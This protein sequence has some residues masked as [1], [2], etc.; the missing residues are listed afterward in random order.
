MKTIDDYKRMCVKCHRN[1]DK[2]RKGVSKH[3]SR[4]AK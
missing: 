1:Y 3:V 4:K 2:N